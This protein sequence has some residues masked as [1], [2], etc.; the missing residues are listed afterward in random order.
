[1]GLILKSY[2]ALLIAMAEMSEAWKNPPEEKKLDKKGLYYR[3][4]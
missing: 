3:I 1:M 4:S 2:S